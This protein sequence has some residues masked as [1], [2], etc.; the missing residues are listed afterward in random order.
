MDGLSAVSIAANFGSFIILEV[1]LI[2]RQ[3][4]SSSSGLTYFKFLSHYPK[5]SFLTIS[6]LP[7]CLPASTHP[8]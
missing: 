7:A 4:A 8:L 2:V 3:K 5:P 1:M 6:N